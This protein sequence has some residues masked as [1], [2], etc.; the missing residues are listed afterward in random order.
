MAFDD[1]RT[2]AARPVLSVRLRRHDRG[3]RAILGGISLDVA[4]GETLA[5]TGVSGIGKSTLMRLIAGLDRPTAGAVAAPDRIG[6]VFQ[7]PTLLPWRSV[8]DNMTLVAGTDGAGVEA[9]LREVGLSGHGRLFPGQLSLGQQ[10]RL[11]LARAFACRP[12]LLLMDEPFVSLDAE[13][14]A[15]MAT[16]FCRLRDRSG[17][18]TILVTHAPAEAEALADRIVRLAG[19]PAVVADIRATGRAGPGPRRA[20]DGIPVVGCHD[21]GA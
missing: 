15:E 6:M 14:A 13:T 9:A 10:R 18:A 5:L 17:V 4:P 8:A 20:R 16:L 1:T 7:E 11:A 2:R 3:G 19:A 12:D 21:A